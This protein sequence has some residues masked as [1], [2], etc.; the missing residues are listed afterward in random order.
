MRQPRLLITLPEDVRAKIDAVRGR[1]PVATWILTEIEKKA[2]W[3]LSKTPSGHRSTGSNAGGR[4][5]L[6]FS[7]SQ[8]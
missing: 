7:N 6:D 1:T 8:E 4:T 5:D 2:D 3:L